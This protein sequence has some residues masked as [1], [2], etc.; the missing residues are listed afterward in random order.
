MALSH[1]IADIRINYSK[2]ELTEDVVSKDPLQQ[3]STWLQEA[4]EAEVLEPTA[5]VLSTVDN[6][7]RP[8]SRV[9]L[10]KDV[11]EN[12]FTFFTN[13]ESRKGRCIE[14]NPFVALTFFW[15]E[16]ERQVRIEGQVRKVDT[17]FSDDYF[18]SRPRGSQIGAWA[19]PQS[20]EISSRSVLEDAGK[21]YEIEFADKELVPRP[22]HWGGYSLSPDYI[23]FWQGRPNRLHDRI[24]FEKQETTWLTK[25]LAP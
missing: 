6:R 24:V 17:G 7:N 8:S 3:F 11:S 16:L 21:R 25:R 13:Y 22:P 5:F 19:S 20:R 15:P 18:H 1:N 10:L 14:E 2:K 4:I 12:G 9:L 23:E